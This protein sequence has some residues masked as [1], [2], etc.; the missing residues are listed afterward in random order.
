MPDYLCRSG[1]NYSPEYVVVSCAAY[2]NNAGAISGCFNSS[3]A[4]E[5]YFPS[6]PD[7]LP[8]SDS[9]LFL[10][11]MVGIVLVCAFLSGLSFGSR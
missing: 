6:E 7:S 3:F 10:Y 9:G 2:N 11:A 8:Y 1:S 4:C 5:P